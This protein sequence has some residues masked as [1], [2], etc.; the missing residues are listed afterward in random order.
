MS[1]HALQLAGV[2][3]CVVSTMAFTGGAADMDRMAEAIR[4]EA[5]LPNAGP[6]GR[7][8][9]LATAWCSGTHAWSEGWRP[10]HQLERIEQGH[11][12]L[13]WFAHPGR[14]Q[15][16]DEKAEAAF[17]EYYEAPIKRAAEL[18]LPLTFI[19]SQWESVLTHG[20]W[21]KLPPEQNPH[22]VTPEGKIKKMMSP[23]GPIAPWREAG[24]TF[25]DN[26]RMRLLQEWYPDPPLVIFLSNNEHPKLRWHKVETSKRYMDTY[27]EGHDADFKRKVVADGWIERYRALQAGMR[28]GLDNANWRQTAKFVAYSADGPE[29]F[30]RWG[31]WV[32]YSLHSPGRISPYPLMWDGGSPSYYTHEWCPTTDHRTWSRQVE[33]MNTVF[34]L[35]D[36]YE[37]NPDWWYEFSTWDGHEWPWRKETPSKVMVY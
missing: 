30:G 27:G 6:Q 35:E 7:P 9:P 15:E 4:T 16:L 2:V 36:A 12:L 25:T 32:H 19:A 28:E 37:L 26:T 29:Y 22:V 23:F 18:H 10:V 17:R 14:G 21:F 31:G 1:R 33:F 8:L 5:T 11:F 34:M 24:R 3:I 13:P 20:Q